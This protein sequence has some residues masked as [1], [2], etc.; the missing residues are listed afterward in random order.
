LD[1]SEPLFWSIV[2]AMYTVS[3]ASGKAYD[4]RRLEA[5]N[6]RKTKFACLYRAKR[7]DPQFARNAA[8]MG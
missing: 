8:A 2:S 5:T 1:Y 3:P 6:G 4:E 7:A